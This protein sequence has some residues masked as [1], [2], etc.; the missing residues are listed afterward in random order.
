[1]R[2]H[3]PKPHSQAKVESERYAAD[4][5]F[6]AFPERIAYEQDGEPLLE[7]Y[8]VWSEF[9]ESGESLAQFYEARYSK[10]WYDPEP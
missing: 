8:E 2:R 7:G 1:L 10:Y 3:P 4:N 5:D 6:E 9:L